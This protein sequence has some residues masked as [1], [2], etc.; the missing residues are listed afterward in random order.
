MNNETQFYIQSI[1]DV[2]SQR[3]PFFRPF[4]YG[5]VVAQS[6]C[7]VH[8]PNVFSLVL[9]ECLYGEEDGPQ[10]LLR[11]FIATEDHTLWLNDPSLS[12][13]L[14]SVAP[15]QHRQSITLIPYTRNVTNVVFS[16]SPGT[17][18]PYAVTPYC[19]MS[20][21]LGKG[22]TFEP[23]A[24]T[25]KLSKALWAECDVLQAPRFHPSDEIHTVSL[26]KGEPAVWCVVEDRRQINVCPATFSISPAHDEELRAWTPVG[27]YLRADA[28]IL[29]DHINLLLGLSC[30]KDGFAF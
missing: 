13:F 15:H 22:G 24:D 10:G 25:A 6:R 28:Q 20:P 29:H 16:D 30:F 3:F 18:G 7:N 9:G 12:P 14:P 21:L 4:S 5:E 26:P 2:M 11:V 27:G 8:G 17:Y 1:Q 23:L 19:Y